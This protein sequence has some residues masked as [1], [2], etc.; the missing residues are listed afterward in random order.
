MNN[1]RIYRYTVAIVALLAFGGMAY[2]GYNFIQALQEGVSDIRSNV[3]SASTP[4]GVPD[5]SVATSSFPVSEPNIGNADAASTGEDILIQQGD[6]A[7]IGGKPFVHVQLVNEGKFIASS[8]V[9]SLVLQL[10]D[11]NSS[12]MA[13]LVNAPLE[14]GLA[15]GEKYTLNLPI[16]DEKWQSPKIAQ[17]Q[18]RKVLAQVVSVGDMNGMGVDYPQISAPVRLQ[19]SQNDWVIPVASEPEISSSEISDKENTPQPV[20]I[21]S[22]NEDERLIESLQDDVPTGEPRVLY[23]K[24]SESRQN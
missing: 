17:A 15:V 9:L 1:E 23:F 18:S 24:Q 21:T 2:K 10:D 19:Q 5:F 6:F 11:Q 20:N 12:D 13:T 14:N 22:D 7:Y 8:V 16:N 4:I 3:I